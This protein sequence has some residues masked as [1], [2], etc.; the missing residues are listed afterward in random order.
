[1]HDKPFPPISRLRKLLKP[2]SQAWEELADAKSHA[3][4]EI[5]LRFFVNSYLNNYNRQAKEES[6]D[7]RLRVKYE[8]KLKK[9]E[10]PIHLVKLTAS[11]SGGL[12][13]SH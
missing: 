3:E 8:I 4:K 12:Y 5:H 1:M 11:V 13:T 9:G 2:G 10:F 6:V 7:P